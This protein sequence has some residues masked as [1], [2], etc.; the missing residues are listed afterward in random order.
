MYS[1]YLRGSNAAAS[2]KHSFKLGQHVVVSDLRG[3][4]AAAS[5][6]PPA[7]RTG[8]RNNLHLRGSNA[9]ASLKLRIIEEHQQFPQR[10]SAAVM[11][12]PH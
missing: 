12:R 10:I 4:N 11:P 8:R 5:L 3:S 6:K 2:L 7:L 1:F 9:A